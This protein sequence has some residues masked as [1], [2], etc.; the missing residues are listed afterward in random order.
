MSNQH[1]GATGLAA[2]VASVLLAASL[3]QAEVR[4]ETVS[5]VAQGTPQR[6]E[7]HRFDPAL[8]TLNGATLT[9]DSSISASTGVA[10]NSAALNLTSVT[11]SVFGTLTADLAAGGPSALPSSIALFGPNVFLGSR[12]FVILGPLAHTST[13]PFTVTNAPT[14]Q[15]F[16]G[17]A[18]Q[19]FLGTGTFAYDFSTGAQASVPARFTSVA[20]TPSAVSSASTVASPSPSP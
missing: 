13:G 2:L 17:A 18:L 11:V 14:V 19:S 9:L 20:L 1:P 8:G 5:Y 3:A 12:T 10:N 16:S 6:L 15:T 4:V 7:L